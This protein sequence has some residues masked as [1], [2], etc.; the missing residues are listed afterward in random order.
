M[1]KKFRG[2]KFSWQKSFVAKKCR[3]KK[4]LFHKILGKKFR[5]KKLVLLDKKFW[6]QKNFLAKNFRDN[7]FFENNTIQSFSFNSISRK[8][9]NLTFWNTIQYNSTKKRGKNICAKK[10]SWQNFYG[11]FFLENNTI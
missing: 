6:W 2:K 5:G 11:K 4:I 7:F 10:F 1:A 8:P 9:R 3:G